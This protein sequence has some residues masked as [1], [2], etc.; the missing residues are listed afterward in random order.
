MSIACHRPLSGWR[1]LG[2]VLAAAMMLPAQAR[3]APTLPALEQLRAHGDLEI[4]ALAVDL[5]SDRMVASMAPHTRL[6]A[7]SLTK[8]YTAAAALQ[9]WGP[10]HRFVTRL[11]YR[12]ER[13]RGRLHGDLVLVGGGDPGLVKNQLWE[14]AE[15]ARQ[16]GLRRVSGDLV[17][18]QSLFGE[19]GCDTRDRCGA[20]RGSAHA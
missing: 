9:R 18:D 10:E 3:S 16:T 5:E 2:V 1:S 4:S 7:A 17:V 14:L 13:R 8:L 20:R 6:I 15:R 19:V 12:G 11:D